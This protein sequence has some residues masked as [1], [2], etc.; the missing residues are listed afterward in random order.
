MNLVLFEDWRHRGSL[1]PFLNSSLIHY[2]TYTSKCSLTNSH[3]FRYTSFFNVARSGAV[4][5]NGLFSPVSAEKQD[6]KCN[7]VG[8][9]KHTHIQIAAYYRVHG[10]IENTV[11]MFD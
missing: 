4:I 6:L 7:K 9:R 8:I 5:K 3:T 11:L 10:L 2:T 1:S